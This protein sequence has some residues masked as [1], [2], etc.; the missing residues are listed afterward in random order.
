MK[1]IILEIEGM[2]CSA[3]SSGLE[4]YLNKQEGIIKA[5]VNLVM[6]QASIEYDDSIVNEKLLNQ[7]VKEAGF[8]SLGEPDFKSDKKR[9]NELIK[10]IIFSILSIFM[11]YISMGMMIKLPIPIVLDKHHFTFIY[12]ILISIISTIFV[13][14]G[15]DI[16]KSGIKNLIHRMPNM[17]SLIGVGILA[18]YSYSIFFIIKLAIELIKIKPSGFIIYD[19]SQFMSHGFMQYFDNI[20]IESV[21]MIILFVKIGRYIDKQSKAKAVDSI[22]NLVTLTPPKAC[23]K[24]DGKEI[25]VKLSEIN[26]GDIIISKPGERIAVDGTIVKGNTH[27]DESFLTGE[28]NSISKKEGDLV[29][30]GSY[31]YDGY[32]EYEAKNI[33]KESTISHIVDLVVEATNSKAPI[34]RF[35]DIISSYFVPA[36]F[37]IA[38]ITFIAHIV[39]SHELSS[40]LQYAISV[41]VVACPC[42][43]GLATPLAMV[44][45]IG[46]ASKNG[47]VIKSSETIELLNKIDTIVFDKTGT[48]TNGK[49]QIDDYKFV[50]NKDINENIEDF[51]ILQLIE[52]KSNHPIAKSIT[53]DIRYNAND[54]ENIDFQEVQGMGI[55]ANIDKNKYFAGNNKLLDKLKINNIFEKEE[56]AFSKKGESIVYFGKN[57]ALITILGLRDTIKKE[58]K[59]SIQ[60]LK[61]AGKRII[62]LSGDNELTANIIAKEI[63]IDNIYSNTSP[64]GKLEI[65]ENL[66]I[67]K[68]VMMVGDGI[69]DSPSLKKASVGV[70]MSG[71]SEI[72]SD[73]ADV[74]LVDNDLLKIKMLLMIG[75]KT[76]K[77]IKQNLFWALCYNMLMIP[78][79]TGFLPISL[80]PMIASLMMTLSSMTVIINSLR[81]RK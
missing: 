39:I 5:S 55:I 31:N 49:M 64:K 19:Y 66:D 7:F 44:I 26:V 65:I 70:S 40:A 14:W 20:F 52:S 53:R 75:N 29:L 32:I 57:D 11:M 27:T 81:L 68:N 34:A 67:N 21:A 62:M 48:L 60:E 79:A 54:M 36:I 59:Q 3:C 22:K 77:I 15:F 8:K 43:L 71:A 45:S 1:K 80:N 42:T 12:I 13:I 9:K 17:D 10:I 73:S 33:G 28:S 2:T 74:I 61:D 38:I 47:I 35:A 23:I 37:I 4:K 69:N 58:T 50:N 46:R 6:A 72:S 56:K 24:K 63:G 16:I 51:K 78:I 25:F 18:N 41:L 76:I 30:A